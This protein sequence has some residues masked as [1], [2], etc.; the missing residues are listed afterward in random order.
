MFMDI[1]QWGIYL[2]LLL[3]IAYTHR[4]YLPGSKK[5]IL[6]VIGMANTFKLFHIGLRKL[7]SFF[8]GI[9]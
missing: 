5:L 4:A 8:S 9:V 3:R 1:S 6:W 2:F 7:S